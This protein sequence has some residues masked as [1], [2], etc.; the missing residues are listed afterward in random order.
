MKFMF[1][2]SEGFQQ[3]DYGSELNQV[4]YSQGSPPNYD[5]RAVTCP[6]AI[7]W[8]END[9]MAP[10]QVPCIPSTVTYLGKDKI[11][12]SEEPQS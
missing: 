10:P 2:S 3:F 8:A 12:C 1:Y 11:L 5:L 4:K 9:Y 6:T 7:Y